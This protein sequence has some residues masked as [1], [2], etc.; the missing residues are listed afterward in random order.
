MSATSYWFVQWNA[1]ILALSLWQRVPYFC[2]K[3][4]NF[5]LK[6]YRKSLGEMAHAC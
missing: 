3:V 4:W 6:K 2:A 5:M 1:R